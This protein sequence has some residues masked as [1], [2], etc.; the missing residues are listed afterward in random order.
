MD[1]ATVT[2]YHQATQHLREALSLFLFSVIML[3]VWV[4]ILLTTRYKV[5][6]QRRSIPTWI[7]TGGLLVASQLFLLQIA[8]QQHWTVHHSV[9]GVAWFL[10][11]IAGAVCFVTATVLAWRRIRRQRA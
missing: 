1:R 10:L 7:A 6:A 11:A 2:A 3:M 5:P 9:L 8:S 4:G